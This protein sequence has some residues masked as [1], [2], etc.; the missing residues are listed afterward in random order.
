MWVQSALNEDLAKNTPFRITFGWGRP[1]RMKLP[2]R[3]EHVFQETSPCRKCFKKGFVL[4]SL[5]D[6]FGHQR[7]QKDDLGTT[8]KF[9]EKVISPFWAKV[10]KTPQKGRDLL[11]LVASIFRPF[12]HLGSRW[13]PKVPPDAPGGGFERIWA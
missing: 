12:S 2:C 9:I 4:T 10:R 13:G 7:P 5:F 3:R 11:V 8:R 6:A 1:L